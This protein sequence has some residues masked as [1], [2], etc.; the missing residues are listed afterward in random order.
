MLTSI[1]SFSRKFFYVNQAPSDTFSTKKDY[2]IQVE[3]PGVKREDIQIECESGVLDVTAV[4][5]ENFPK[6]AEQILSERDYGKITRSF[7]LPRA[8]DTSKIGAKFVDG[9]LSI[10]LPRN[11][12]ARICI[13]PE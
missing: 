12:S 13:T 3:L 7:T 10:N 1:S 6:E 9:V 2:V 5:K 8:V 11:T 4:K